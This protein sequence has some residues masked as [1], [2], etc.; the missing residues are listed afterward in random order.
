MSEEIP[1]P[2]LCV[3]PAWKII[4]WLNAEAVK[5]A[6]A[7]QDPGPWAALSL[8]VENAATIYSRAHPLSKVGVEKTCDKPE[9]SED[10]EDWGV[11]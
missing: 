7:G 2:G 6:R 5:A 8:A 11:M 3:I 1:P 10:A 9:S 4:A